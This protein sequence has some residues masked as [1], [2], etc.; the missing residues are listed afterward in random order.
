MIAIIRFLTLRYRIV[1]GELII[2]SGLINR[3]HRTVPLSRI[4]N[5]DLSQNIFHR[6]LRVG[7]MRVETA[8]GKEPEAKMRVYRS[9]LILSA[10]VTVA[11]CFWS[12]S[13]GLLLGAFCLVVGWIY[14]RKK[15]KSRRYART[16]WGLVY[17]S[18]TL[19]RKCSM[20]F[21]EKLQSVTV[22][23]SPFDRRWNMATLAADTAAAGPANHRIEVDYL[24][25]EHA[26]NELRDIILTSDCV[27]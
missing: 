2:D 23:Q 13:T 10:L 21:F 25:S 8:S 3:L 22:K 20:T 24:D 19:E 6:M 27:R 18:G 1:S 7:E 16:A 9:T 5:I 11:V 12:I 4:Q 14:V 26:V 17:R 15:A